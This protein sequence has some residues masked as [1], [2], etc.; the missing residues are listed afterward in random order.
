MKSFV[1]KYEVELHATKYVALGI[2]SIVLPF[3]II[4]LS[5]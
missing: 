2:I 4:A 5:Y 1:D 3:A